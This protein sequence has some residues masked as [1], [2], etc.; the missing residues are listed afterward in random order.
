MQILIRKVQV[1]DHLTTRQLVYKAFK[2]AEPE[3]TALFLD[4][5]RADNCILGEWLAE[6]I[7][8]VVA[9][10]VFSRVYVERMDGSQVSAAMLTPLAVRPDCQR[11]GLGLR[12]MQFS[13]EKLEAEGEALFFVLGHPSYYPRAGFHSD[14]ALTVDS[15]WGLKSAFMARGR[16]IPIGKLLLPKSIAEAH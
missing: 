13:L 2:G 3:E 12:L 9:H 7:T 14:L 11:M 8:G 4:N 16:N 5:L 15:P 1:Q 6:N 10:I